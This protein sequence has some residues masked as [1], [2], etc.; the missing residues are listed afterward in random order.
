MPPVF[1]RG[2]FNAVVAEA[3]WHSAPTAGLMDV[4]A[5]AVHWRKQCLLIHTVKGLVP[6]V[7]TNY[8][9]RVPVTVFCLSICSKLDRWNPQLNHPAD[10]RR[11][12]E[13]Q[14]PATDAALEQQRDIGSPISRASAYLNCQA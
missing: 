6:Q 4:E 5:I 9:L 11:S 1:H 8:P 10:A 7:K 3:L 2:N 12:L 13:G 14:R